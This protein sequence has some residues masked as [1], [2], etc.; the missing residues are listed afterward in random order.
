MEGNESKNNKS[1]FTSPAKGV[2]IQ[3]TRKD[4]DSFV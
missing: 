3:R 4:F 2:S 1:T